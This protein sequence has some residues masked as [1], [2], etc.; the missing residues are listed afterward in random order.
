MK[1]P[2]LSRQIEAAIRVYVRGY[3]AAGTGDITIQVPFASANEI[4]AAETGQAVHYALVRAGVPRSHIRVA[5]YHFGDRARTS[6]LRLSYLRVKAVT[7]TCGLWPETQPTNYRNADYDNFGCATQQ[8]LAAMVANPAD[9]VQPQPMTP[10]DGAR[11]AAVV[12][13]YSD[14]GN[15]GWAPAPLQALPSNGIGG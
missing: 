1:G 14:I 13:T 3:R 2:A 10:P 9:L 12:K 15:T 6:S 7:P 4:A 8:N 5:P 11:R